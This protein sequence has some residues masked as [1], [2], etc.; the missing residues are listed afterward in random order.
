MKKYIYDEVSRNRLFNGMIFNVDEVK[1]KVNEHEK[2]HTYH[3]VGLHPI[4]SVTEKCIIT[5]QVVSK[6]PCVVALV[7]HI[8]TNEFFILKEFRVGA[9]KEEWGFVAGIIDEGET[10]WG[11]IIREVQEEIGYKPKLVEQIG[12]SFSSSGFTDEHIT[13]FYIEV[14][15]TMKADKRTDNDEFIS[16]MLVGLDNIK[17]MIAS[18]AIKNNHA[19]A[20][21]LHYLLSKEGTQ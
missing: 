1:I 14:S 17:K 6:R 20:C 10:A 5:R 15:D 7:K 8:E 18:G 16:E 21:Y 12:E 9:M 19:K 3:T 11:A 2:Y 13:Y 4:E